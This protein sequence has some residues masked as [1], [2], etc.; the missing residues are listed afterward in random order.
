MLLCFSKILV[1]AFNEFPLQ[2]AAV[3]DSRWLPPAQ[4]VEQPPTNLN[5][6]PPPTEQPAACLGHRQQQPYKWRHAAALL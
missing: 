6:A 5:H 2:P 1:E 4:R 3:T